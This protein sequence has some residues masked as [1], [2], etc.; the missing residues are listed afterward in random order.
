MPN[1]LDRGRNSSSTTWSEEEIAQVQA[2][3]K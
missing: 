3:K 2:G 1:R